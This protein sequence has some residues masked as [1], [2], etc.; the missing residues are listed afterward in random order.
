LTRYKKKYESEVKDGVLGKSDQ[1]KVA[2]VCGKRSERGQE[3]LRR[4]VGLSVGSSRKGGEE[5]KNF[6]K[7][8]GWEGQTLQV[9]DEANLEGGGKFSAEGGVPRDMGKGRR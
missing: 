1:E 2:T 5:N 3:P 9:E 6:Y 4:L 8:G 7:V